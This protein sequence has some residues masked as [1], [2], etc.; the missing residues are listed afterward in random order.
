MLPVGLVGFA[1]DSGMTL[2]APHN[3]HEHSLS[4]CCRFAD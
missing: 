2:G 3:E 4:V 1:D